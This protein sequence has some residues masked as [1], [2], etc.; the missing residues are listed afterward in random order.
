[1]QL[2]RQ[3][4]D[5]ISLALSEMTDPILDELILESV[6]PAPNASRVQVLFVPAK[7]SI[8]VDA[9]MARLEEVAG[10]LRSEV[11]AEV[12][13]KKAPELVFRVVPRMATL[14]PMDSKPPSE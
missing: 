3:V 1:M 4:F 12:N 2:C 9:A 6:T 8:D 7:E 5:A 11:A 10:E 13:R 14:P